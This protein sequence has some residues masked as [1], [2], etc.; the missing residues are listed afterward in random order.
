MGGVIFEGGT[1]RP[2]F[3][4]GIMD[5]LNDHDIMFPYVIGVSAGITDAFSY[6]SHQPKRNLN[7]LLE[8]RNNPDYISK[9]NMLKGEHSLFGLKYAFETIPNELYPFDYETFN[10]SQTKILVGVTNCKTGKIEYLDGHTND[11]R[12]QMIK[13]TCAIPILFPPIDVNGQ[14]YYDGGLCDPIPVRKALKDGNKKVL[15]VLTRPKGYVK[16]L[17]KS[18][19]MAARLIKKKFPNLV[20]PLLTRHE[21]YNETV[22]YCEA[23]EANGQALIIRPDADLIVESMEKDLDKIKACYQHGYDLAEKHLAEIIEIVN[24]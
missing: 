5:C 14:L 20:E 19:R 9:R 13:A 21:A 17:T 22:K 12:N 18:N 16:T 24:S 1:F 2:I 23:L 10:K 6:V 11:R 3:S 15:I 7:I 4:C 8:N